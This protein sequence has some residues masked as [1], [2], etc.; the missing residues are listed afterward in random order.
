VTA[1][2]VI[3]LT[4][5]QRRLK[6]LPSRFMARVDIPLEPAE[7]DFMADAQIGAD[8]LHTLAQIDKGSRAA[9]N[10]GYDRQCR[11]VHF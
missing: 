2:A 6:N 5:L 3:S 10:W 1:F 9:I 4:C 8:L 11:I 7:N